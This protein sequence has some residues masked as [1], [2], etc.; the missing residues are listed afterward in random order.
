M[1]ARFPPREREKRR[2]VHQRLPS[3]QSRG[4]RPH[5]DQAGVNLSHEQDGAFHTTRYRIGQLQ[6]GRKIVL[7]RDEDVSTLNRHDDLV[8]L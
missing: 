3:R 2:D 4:K 8:E 7:T 6:R 5:I 1:S